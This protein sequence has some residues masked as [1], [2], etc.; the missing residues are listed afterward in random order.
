MMT[1]PRTLPLHCLTGL[2]PHVKPEALT[3]L[4]ISG[5]NLKIINQQTG[6]VEYCFGIWIFLTFDT[7]D[8]DFVPQSRRYEPH[9][10]LNTCLQTCCLQRSSIESSVK[11]PNCWLVEEDCSQISSVMPDPIRTSEWEERSRLLDHVGTRIS[12]NTDF[13]TQVWISR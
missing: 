5:I 13:K 6:V 8:N 10:F 4:K 3:I 7:F 11:L 2:T 1:G 9:D 12:T